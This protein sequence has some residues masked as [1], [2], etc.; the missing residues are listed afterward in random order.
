[1]YLWDGTKCMKVATPSYLNPDKSFSPVTQVKAVPYGYRS[2][3][4]TLASH[5]MFYSAHRGGSADWPEMTLYAYTQ[6][7]LAGVGILEVSLARTSDG[8]WFGLHDQ[9]LFR[10]SGVLLDPKTMTWAEVQQFSVTPP[11]G[12]LPQPSRP[13]MRLEQL[14]EA[15]GNTHTLMFDP[16]YALSYTGNLLT[17]LLSK[18]SPDRLMGKYYFDN[19][20]FANACKGA[21]IKTWGYAYEKDIAEVVKPQYSVWD[22]YG[23]DFAA[24]QSAWTAILALGKPVIGHICATREDMSMAITK[25]ASGLQVSGVSKL[26]HVGSKDA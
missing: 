16:K 24:S 15:Y 19:I 7:V 17:T 1:M 25:G 20:T 12:S 9:T 26:F 5:T 18:V 10:T 3:S 23:M 21:G 4:R 14:M 8:V 2:I 22:T 11:E 6:S 13:Y